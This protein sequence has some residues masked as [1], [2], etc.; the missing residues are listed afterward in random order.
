MPVHHSRLTL[1][2]HD[3]WAGLSSIYLWPLLGWQDIKQR[4]RRSAIGPFWITLSYGTL[5]LGMGLLYGKLLQQ[6][7]S[8]Y[9]PY[10]AVGFVAGA[11]NRAGKGHA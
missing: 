9:L 10:L 3:L 7:M 8:E 2:L 11:L 1:A 6:D 5:I 4:Y